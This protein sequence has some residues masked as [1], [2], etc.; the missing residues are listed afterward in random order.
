MQ[1]NEVPLD[2][3][4]AMI[5]DTC[6]MMWIS[7]V[8][9]WKTRTKL[10]G[11]ACVLSLENKGN[12]LLIINIIYKYL[13]LKRNHICTG[14]LCSIVNNANEY[15]YTFF[16]KLRSSLIKYGKNEISA[17]YAAACIYIHTVSAWYI[18]LIF[19]V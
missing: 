13:P 18:N 7:W 9:R 1:S 3:Y 5:Y 10:D 12:A 15:M 11:V 14:A 2:N 17:S 4:K 16:I 19:V 8:T 6:N